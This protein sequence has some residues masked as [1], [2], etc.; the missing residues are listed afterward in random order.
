MKNIFITGI[1][2]F[3]GFHLAKKLVELKFNVVGIDNFNT[4][5]D[6]ALKQIRAKILKEKGVKIYQQDLSVGLKQIIEDH[7]VTNIVH[8]A[9]QAGVRYSLENPSAYIDS[10]IHGFLTILEI[11]RSFPHI[12]LVYASSSSIYGLNKDIPFKETHVTDKQ[13]S[14]YGVTKKTNELMAANYHHLFNIKVTGLR[15]FTV[16]GPYGRPD[17]AYFSFADAI[18]KQTPIYL[19]NQG[20][21][22]RD[23]TFIDDITDGIISA[24]ELEASYE[25]FNLGNNQSVS[26]L[27]FVELLEKYMGKTTK[28]IFAPMQL[29][30]VENTFADI[31]HAQT[32][33]GYSPKTSIEKGLESFILWYKEHR[34]L[35]S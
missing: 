25:I 6:P 17:M 11:C 35:F 3:I 18:D 22:K 20:L 2:G 12:P 19:Y 14:L 16:Y 9:A 10:N 1:A 7:N 4:Y 26:L 23:F 29:G 33:L 21:M 34:L 13:A 31:T 24:I 28:K 30:D 15:F 8:L 5:Y 27:Y 32:Q